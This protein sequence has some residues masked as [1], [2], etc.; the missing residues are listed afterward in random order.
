IPI[1]IYEV[2][3]DSPVTLLSLLNHVNSVST[4]E[5]VLPVELVCNEYSICD[6]RLING[7]FPSRVVVSSVANAF[8]GFGG[9]GDEM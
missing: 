9:I 5:R 8:G 3:F 6:T 2:V 1:L 4:K 7:V